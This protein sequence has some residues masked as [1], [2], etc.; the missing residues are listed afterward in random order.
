M[1]PHA[2]GYG[3]RAFLVCGKVRKQAIP[4]VLMEIM[5]AIAG[6]GNGNRPARDKTS[7]T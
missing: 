3:M 6:I 2:N 4:M 7:S 5:N 1:P